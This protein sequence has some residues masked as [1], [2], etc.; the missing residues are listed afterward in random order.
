MNSGWTRRE[1]AVAALGMAGAAVWVRMSSGAMALMLQPASGTGT[2]PNPDGDPAGDARP[3]ILDPVLTRGRSRER[4][5]RVN[6]VID[7]YQTPAERIP[8]DRMPAI[9]KLKF[10][11][12]AIVFPLLPKTG[13]SETKMERV[14]GVMSFDD[15]PRDTQVTVLDDYPCGSKLGRWELK[16]MEG[17]QASLELEI[18][19][20][21]WR[22]IYDEKAAARAVWPQGGWGAVGASA[23]APQ[24]F[25][26]SNDP[27]VTEQVKAWT[28]GKDPK[29]IA[30]AQLAKF[31]AGKVVEAVQTSGNGQV[32]NRRNN[33]FAGLELAGAAATLRAGRGTEHDIAAALTAVYRAAGLPARVVIGH[34]DKSS[35]TAG[36]PGGAFDKASG[37][38][39][40]SWTEFCL[41]DADTQREVW[42]PVDPKS[43]RRFSSRAQPLDRPWKYFGTHDELDDVMPF[44]FHFH[45]PTTVVA[46][47]AAAFWGWLTVPE[48]QAA[49]Q[50]LRFSSITTPIGGKDKKTTEQKD[51]PRRG[52]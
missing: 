37:P 47:G 49:T 7:G 40:R 33:Q 18:P 23:L 31:L 16:D 20:T 11:T 45:P 2:P 30:P 26:D 13:S 32:G 46:H 43:I 12:A 51:Q 35:G 22:T 3:S 42:V 29:S 10:E 5:L 25:V 36:G 48:T 17:R 1:L 38:N 50:Y 52:R 39:L 27:V 4:T 41:Y 44:A 21:T 8:T 24:M 15:Q 19:M 6:I 9:S 28:G 14:K 34:Q